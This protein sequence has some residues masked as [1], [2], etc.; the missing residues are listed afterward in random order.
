MMRK[1]ELTNRL[2]AYSL[3]L[4]LA[5]ILYFIP[6]RILF[7]SKDSFCLHKII[8]G[9]ECPLCGMTRASHELLHLRF[10]SAFRYNFNVF[11]LSFFILTDFANFMLPDLHLGKLK[12]ITL[13]LFLIGLGI[14]YIMRFGFYFG[15]L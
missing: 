3:L 11:L 1:A 9:I 4:L 8:L 7:E 13:I 2:I 14:I 15:W 10:L 5:A 12:K 6:D